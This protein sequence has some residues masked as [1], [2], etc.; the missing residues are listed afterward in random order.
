MIVVSSCLFLGFKDSAKFHSIAVKKPADLHAIFKY[1]GEKTPFVSAHRGGS[2]P[3]FPENSMAT[4][5][6]TL[7]TT[8]AIIELD[9]R[10]TRDSAMVI[11]HDPALGRTSEGKGNVID[12]TL[13]ELLKL[14][15]KDSKGNL[16]DYHMPTFDEVLEW[17]KGKTILVIDQK[18][19]SAKDRLR[20]VEEH[21]AVQNVILIVY[22]FE[23][24][25]LCYSLNKDV[26]MEVMIPDEQKMLE[27]DKTGVPWSN[28]VAF[29]GHNLPVDS[30]LFEMIHKRGALCMAGSSRNVDRKF[31]TGQIT[32]FNK[33]KSEYMDFFS[34][35]IDLIETDVPVYL[36]PLV[37]PVLP[38][39][40]STARFYR[41]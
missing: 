29:V 4:Y 10:Y 33:L 5:E 14:R 12:F 1:R 18:D 7:K 9:P 38:E 8:F 11:H 30:K 24:A 41:E 36:G 32:D 40:L 35:G 16:T 13:T 34:K 21:N 15:L 3:G 2:L 28:V 27:F 17:A 31:L 23:D 20:K 25:R 39:K 19:V 37:N 26:M 22:S 6:N